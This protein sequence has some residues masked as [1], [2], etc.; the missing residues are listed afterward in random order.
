MCSYLYFCCPL[1]FYRH[2]DLRIRMFRPMLVY[3]TFADTTLQDVESKDAVA[4]YVKK[5]SLYKQLEEALADKY[6]HQPLQHV[7]DEPIIQFGTGGLV[8]TVERHLKWLGWS[9]ALAMALN[10]FASTKFMVKLVAGAAV[11]FCASVKGI[12]WLLMNW[13]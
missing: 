5:S 13:K 11:T 2:Q 8:I 9:F 3:Q 4:R 12:T 1:N 10:S 7:L 6:T